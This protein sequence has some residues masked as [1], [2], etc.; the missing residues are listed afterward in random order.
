V[1]FS[2]VSVDLSHHQDKPYLTEGTILF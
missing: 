2:T 1:P